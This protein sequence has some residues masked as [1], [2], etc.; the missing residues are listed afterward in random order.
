MTDDD[1]QTEHPLPYPYE[2]VISDDGSVMVIDKTEEPKDMLI[3]DFDLRLLRYGHDEGQG[4]ETTTFEW[5]RPHAG[6][7]SFSLRQ[8]LL[9]SGMYKEFSM[10]IADMGIIFLSKAQTIRFQ[11]MLRSYLN[12]LK[13]Q[14]PMKNLYSSM[15]WKK[16]K[17]EFLVGKRLLQKTA[18]G[19]KATNL[20][21]VS[22]DAKHISD[23]YSEKGSFSDWVEGVR[24]LDREKLRG[25]QMSL[26][27]GFASILMPFVGLNGMVV[28]FYGP[29]GTGKTIAQY[30]QQSVW[31]N[32]TSLHFQ[33]QYTKNAVYNRFGAQC[34]LPMTIDE[35]TQIGPKEL[36]AFL[37]E[38][39]QGRDKVRLN[40]AAKQIKQHEWS[41]LTT[42]STNSRMSQ[43]LHLSG[44]ESDAQLLRL[45][46]FEI[47]PSEV[48]NGQNYKG[49]K[50][51]DTFSRNYGWAGPIF[52]KN[53]LE[54]GEE[55]IRQLIDQTME[56]FESR[57]GRGFAGDERYWQAAFVLCDLAM[58]L[59]ESWGILPFKGD[60][61]IKWGLSALDDMHETIIENRKYPLDYLADYLNQAEHESIRIVYPYNATPQFDS[62]RVP[63]GKINVRYEYDR[64]SSGK[65]IG[66]RL[67]INK[68]DFRKYLAGAGGD[69]KAFKADT[70]AHGIWIDVKGGKK[71][72]G[73][74]SPFASMQAYVV[75]LDIGHKMM[76]GMMDEMPRDDSA[77]DSVVEFDKDMW[78]K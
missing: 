47:M 49:K 17:T 29:S 22:E 13:K 16:E 5:Q 6:W 4:W 32:P 9:V 72:M 10:S 23:F 14:V 20:S 67:Y 43:K 56:D 39:S 61:V 2:K 36:G 11:T 65:C 3:C 73:K 63:R 19:V 26:A 35:A 48:F 68:P 51:F 78:R 55:K 74:D 45:L 53:L 34:N 57:Y 46:E 28:S 15:G 12:D 64:N 70:I 33:S 62:T 59:C 7:D 27:L 18:Q 77:F 8:A 1:T 37:Y 41:L 24:D 40:K 31:G 69:W 76:G 75:C 21:V 50:I 42:M 44:V 60:E 54:M 25:Q 52:A 30:I 71:S 58:H 66:G 38:V